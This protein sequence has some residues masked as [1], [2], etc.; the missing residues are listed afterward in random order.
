MLAVE[1]P[2]VLLVIIIII[3]GYPTNWG[4]GQGI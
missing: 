3:I 2:R 1:F 4:N